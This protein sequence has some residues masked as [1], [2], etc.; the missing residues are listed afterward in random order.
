M[1]LEDSRDKGPDGEDLGQSF[2]A[3]TG[4]VGTAFEE[5]NASPELLVRKKSHAVLWVVLVLVALVAVFLVYYLTKP[6]APPAAAGMVW[7]AE[8]S[9]RLR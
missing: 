2:E 7:P 6:K 5:R 9:A 3:H 1:A 4:N 8:V